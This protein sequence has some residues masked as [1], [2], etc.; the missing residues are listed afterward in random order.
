MFINSEFEEGD[1]L[2]VMDL[3]GKVV[4]QYNVPVASGLFE[5]NLAELESGVYFVQHSGL[6]GRSQTF[7][8]V[9]NN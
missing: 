5:I 2:T 3:S 6:N 9:K 7:K 1:I 8:V 4:G